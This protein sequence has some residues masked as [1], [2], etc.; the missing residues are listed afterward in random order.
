MVTNVKL[1]SARR[2]YEFRSND[3]RLTVLTIPAVQSAIQQRFNFQQAEIAKPPVTFGL[4]PDSFPPGLAFSLGVVEAGEKPGT[5]IRYLF[6]EPL[7]IVLDL[8]GPS[9]AID[10]AFSQLRDLL[11]DTRAPDG[12]PVL[13]EPA[14]ALERTDISAHFDFPLAAVLSPRL[15]ALV[16]NTL[17]VSE[18]RSSSV[19]IP[20][21]SIGTLS[22]DSTYPGTSPLP[23][24]DAFQLQL[25]SG[26]PPDSGEYFSSAPLDTDRHLAYLEELDA[27]LATRGP[28]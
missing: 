14:R 20:N 27:A 11:A 9:S 8:A 13:G 2:A 12:H 18:A 7:R 3:L 17:G 25:R 6:V 10:I 26:Y 24:P 4:V 1:L 28:K 19:L 16:K 23:E 5:F 22:R 15:R 21:L